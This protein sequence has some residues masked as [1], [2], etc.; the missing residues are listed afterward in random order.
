MTTVTAWVSY[1]QRAPSGAYIASDSL[2]STP[3]SGWSSARKTFHSLH[4]PE[5]F[6]YIGDVLFPSLLLGQHVA[7]LDSGFDPGLEVSAGKRREVL[8][9]AVKR[10]VQTYPQE[11]MAGGTT[12]IV[13]IARQGVGLGVAFV[14]TLIRINGPQVSHQVIDS[15]DS[16]GILEFTADGVHEVNRPILEGSGADAVETELGRWQA[17]DRQYLSRRVFESHC[18]AIESGTASGS[19]GAPQLVGLYREGSGRAFGFA[20][21]GQRPSLFGSPIRDDDALGSLEYRNRLFER[22][23]RAGGLLPGAKSHEV[24]VVS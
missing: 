21:P 10:A 8:I 19:G 7:L 24:E 23:D 2:I 22:V 11:W 9:D 17:T 16:A 13:H 15:L 3:S 6:A 4:H 14:T 20:A 5:V 1:D 12:T 18:R